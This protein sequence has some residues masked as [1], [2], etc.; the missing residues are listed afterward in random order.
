MW[1][2]YR[3]PGPPK[4]SQREGL[5][6]TYDQKGPPKPSQRE[7]LACTQDQQIETA[8]HVWNCT[9]AE[10]VEMKL[11]FVMKYRSLPFGKGDG[12][13]GHTRPED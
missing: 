2:R 6:C 1:G 12:G 5:A 11:V 8:F 9:L 10:V 13:M 3:S 7:G 4:P